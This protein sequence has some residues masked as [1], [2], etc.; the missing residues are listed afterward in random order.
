MRVLTVT[1]HAYTRVCNRLHACA[2]NVYCNRVLFTY[3]TSAYTCYKRVYMLQART[4]HVYVHGF[5][6]A[7]DAH[8]YVHGFNR[9]LDACN[10]VYV[11][12]YTRI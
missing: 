9:A 7:L 6:R 10:V 3:V 5:N 8:V 4:I 12:V 11:N 2:V 1:V